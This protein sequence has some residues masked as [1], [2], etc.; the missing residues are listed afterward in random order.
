MKTY[1]ADSLAEQIKVKDPHAW[2]VEA[3]KFAVDKIYTFTAH[4]KQIT[5]QYQ[6]QIKALLFRQIALGGY[7]LAKTIESIMA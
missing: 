6:D 5:Q 7:R 3:Y 2:G 4:N 1:S